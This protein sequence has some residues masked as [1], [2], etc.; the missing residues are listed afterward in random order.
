V[1]PLVIANIGAGVQSTTMLLL[2]IHGELP[3]PDAAIFADTKWE[4]SYVYEQVD[5]LRAQAERA[6]I[7]FYVVTAG[8][9][10]DAIKAAINKAPGPNGGVIGRVSNP[11]FYVQSPQDGPTPKKEGRLRRGCTR[12]YKI[13]PIHRKCRELAEERFGT[14][15]LPENC[16]V[17]W[18]GISLD[19]IH[20]TRS[21]GDRDPKYIAVEYP[22]IDLRFTRLRC[23]DFLKDHGY[24]VPRKSACLGCPFH[25]NAYWR[26]LKQNHPDEF[27]A[28]AEFDQK[29]RS[30]LPGVAGEVYMHRSLIPL[31]QVDLSPDDQRFLPGFAEECDGVCNT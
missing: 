8:A 20:R 27:E 9:L 24:H 23:V 15:R 1:K 29:I 5:W 19:E 26:S 28:T 12:D 30:G 22:L 3:K 10:P 14:K 2:S 25:D 16:V 17:Q 21:K 13:A 31:A 4:P 18:R 6:G 11:P 7:P